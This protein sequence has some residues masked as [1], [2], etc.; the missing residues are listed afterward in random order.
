MK[1]IRIHEYGDASVLTYE[2]A[3]DPSVGPD[4]V[5]IRIV[6]AAVNPIDWKVR[7]GLYKATR[8]LSF[9]AIVGY[10]VAG[11][12]AQVGPLVSRF[13]PGDKVVARVDGSYA[14]FGVANSDRVAP[15]PTSVKLAHAAGLPI[16]AG[17]AWQV[18]FDTARLRAGQTVVIHAGAGGVGSFAVQLA[19]LAGLHVIA[20]ASAGNAELV[21]SLGADVVIDDRVTDL[22]TVAHDVDVVFDT[23]GAEAQARSWKVIRK[24]G[25]LITIAAPPD[26]A[27]AAQH[28]VTA[29]FDRLDLNGARLGEIAGLIDTGKLKLLIEREFSLEQARAAQELSE[30][31][32]SRG[33]IILTVAG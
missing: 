7:K 8:P 19:K 29:S 18:L 26:E 11:T 33:K 21:R 5:L 6:G 27:A 30:A 16:A 14:E 28:G 17:T 9:P 25:R 1:A 4:H 24:G 10:D 32:H 15:A 31:G 13:K 22:G 3:P 23:V 20:T 2:D 12:V